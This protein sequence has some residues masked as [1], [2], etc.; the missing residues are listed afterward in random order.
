VRRDIEITD[1]LRLT[2][3]IAL[4][5]EPGSEGATRA[6]RLFEVMVAGLKG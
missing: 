3:S 4:M 5:V 1:L 6:E 2:H